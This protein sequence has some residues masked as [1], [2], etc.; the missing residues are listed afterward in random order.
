MILALALVATQAP[1]LQSVMMTPPSSDVL[2]CT[3]LQKVADGTMS[4]LPQWVDAVTR[5]DALVVTCGLKTYHVN[6]FI[7]QP[8]S[9]MREGWRGRKEAQ[10]DKQI[11]QGSM[12]PLVENGWRISQVL[13]FASGERIEMDAHCTAV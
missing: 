8:A 2:A 1:P 13:T 6:K 9:E 4:Q 11:C 12:G 3:E 7:N 5:V 10:W